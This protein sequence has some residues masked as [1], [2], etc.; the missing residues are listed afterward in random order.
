MIK[1]ID[2]AHY[3]PQSLESNYD[4]KEKFSIDDN[5]IKE[6]IGV[7]TVSKKAKDEDTSDLCVKAF[8]ELL[9]KNHVSVDELECIVVCT[10]NPDGNGIPHTSAVVHGKL[11]VSESCACFD[12]SLGCSGYVYG[13]SVVSAFMEK[14][15]LKCGLLFTADPYSKILNPDDKNTSLLF[16][17]AASVTL[18]REG[19]GE[20]GWSSSS[21]VF[22]TA[23]KEGS[24]LTNGSGALEMNGRAVFNFTAKAVPVQIQKLLKEARFEI[25]D[26]DLF[27]FHQASKYI[28]DTLQKIMQIPAE[29][30]PI[31][32]SEIGNTVSSTNP[33]I[34]EKRLDNSD[35][36]RLVLSGF[37]VGL[38]WA[39]C[40]L[41]RE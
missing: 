32:L 41:E 19:D 23:G 17:D 16:G 3:V 13:L 8:S 10:Q 11:G 1:I 26:I 21:F 38:S 14:N 34:L 6:K 24:A 37:G 40:I 36:K 5:F 31:E 33:I 27:L 28:L 12:I 29:K 15:N 22:S 9:K 30:I 25:Q 7:E 20:R 35:L 2:I 39:S 4:K 18:L